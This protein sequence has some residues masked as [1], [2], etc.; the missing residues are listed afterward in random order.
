[1]SNN[2]K[3]PAASIFRFASGGSTSQNFSDADNDVNTH[4]RRLIS[5]DQAPPSTAQRIRV[6]HDTLQRL[7]SAAIRDEVLAKATENVARDVTAQLTREFGVIFAALNMANAYVFGGGY[8]EGMIAQEENMFRRT[9]C[10]FAD[11]HFDREQDQYEKHHTDLL[12]ARNGQVYLDTSRP[13]VCIRRSEDR[14]RPDLGYALLDEDDVFPFYELRA[15]AQDLRRGQSFDPRECSKR[16]AAQLDTLWAAGLRHVVLSAFGC[17]AFMNPASEVA[18][19]YYDAILQRLDSFDVIAFAIF[20]AGY[21]A[22]NFGPF[23]Q[24]L[25]PLVEASVPCGLNPGGVL[26]VL[27]QLHNII[28]FRE[29]RNGQWTLPAGTCN[30][31]SSY[32][33]PQLAATDALL[34]HCAARALFETTRGAVLADPAVFKECE[35]AGAT[36]DIQTAE[37]LRRVFYLTIQESDFRTSLFFAGKNCTG[38]PSDVASAVCRVPVEDFFSPVG[39]KV[40]RLR[41]V[42]GIQ[43]VYG[44]LS[45]TR[46]LSAH[47]VSVLTSSPSFL[48]IRYSACPGGYDHIMAV[49]KPQDPHGAPDADAA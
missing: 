17:G 46:D 11:A 48:S 10:H 35:A 45:A 36:R 3:Q 19:C 5:P 32:Y 4:G 31:S 34:H 29:D 23:E 42:S 43:E 12:E 18:R 16:V 28:L 38:L 2:V 39:G 20:H 30:N 26:I 47:T 49:I 15:A 14:S 24:T 13:R 1:M 27:Q 8:V 6:L 40:E 33:P 21:G 9:D 37:G 22:D 7:G 44:F 25:K 41:Q